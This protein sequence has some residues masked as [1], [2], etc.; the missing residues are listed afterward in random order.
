MI[1]QFGVATL[2][3]VTFLA[4]VIYFG[5]QVSPLGRRARRYKNRQPNES[6]RILLP[7][8]EKVMLRYG[9]SEDDGLPGVTLEVHQDN[10]CLQ[11]S[12]T[13]FCPSGDVSVKDLFR[14]DRRAYNY[15]CDV[16]DA[17]LKEEVDELLGYAQSTASRFGL[18]SNSAG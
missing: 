9:R 14:A 13:T 7:G 10:G 17:Q 11:R 2:A 18:S 5:Y 16:G 1:S 8:Y 6:R 15:Y 3:T 12:T 4:T